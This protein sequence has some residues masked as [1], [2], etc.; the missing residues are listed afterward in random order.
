MFRV[1]QGTPGTVIRKNGKKVPFHTRHDL[2]FLPR[3]RL[4]AKAVRDR[5]MIMLNVGQVA[6]ERGGFILILDGKYVSLPDKVREAI[7]TCLLKMRDLVLK[8]EDRLIIKSLLDRKFPLSIGQMIMAAVLIAR[9]RWLLP[10][11]NSK[12]ATSILARQSKKRD[13]E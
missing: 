5:A 13:H 12:L 1:A 7:E 8:Q 11:T 10:E 3:E 4:G 2:I 9:Y 6:F